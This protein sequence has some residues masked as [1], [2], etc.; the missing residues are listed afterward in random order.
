MEIREKLN[1]YQ[2]PIPY[3]SEAEQ[4]E[5]EAEFGSPADEDE[6]W[7]DMTVWV[8]NGNRSTPKGVWTGSEEITENDLAE[9]RQE[10]W[11]QFAKFEP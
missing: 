1:L 10:M 3:V 4:Q 6:E 8:K 11:D 7:I 5:I 9:A 2:D